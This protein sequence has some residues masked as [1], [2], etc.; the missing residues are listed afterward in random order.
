MA[1]PVLLAVD[2]D[3]EVLRAV[4]RDLRRG[5]GREYRVMRAD[6]AGSALDTL[7]ALKGRNDPVALMLVDQRMPQVS[8]VEFLEQA[9][10][11]YPD[12]KRVLLTAYADTDAA[13]R[14]INSVDLDYYL[15]KPWDPPEERLYPVLSDLLGDWQAAYRPP[16]EGVR[17]VGHQWAPRSHAVKDFLSRNQVPYQW[18]DFDGSDE[19]RNLIEQL[20][21]DP[22]KLPL[23]LLTDGTRLQEPSVSQLAEAVGMRTRA[24]QPFYDLIIVGGGPAGL[25]AAVYGGSEGLR[26]L[27]IEREAPG[28]QAGTSSMIRNY[29]GFPSGVTGADLARRALDQARLFEVEI[30][31]V[32]EVC[33]VRAE[34]PYRIIELAGGGEVSCHALLIATGVSW[35]KL[36]A[37]GIDKLTGAGVYYGAAT[38]EALGCR[39]EDVYVVGGANSAGQA[40][41]YFSRFARD[42]HILCRGES[43]TKGMSRY[44]IDEIERTP[45]IHV[46]TR[47]NIAEA[48]GDG[49]LESVVVEDSRTGERRE[50]P[51]SGL[52][53][54]IG[55]E[56]YT[57]WLDGVVMRDEK[58]F[59]LT[60]PDLLRDGKRPR[61]WKLDRDP[62]LLETSTP[63]VFAAGDV[64]RG[65]V[66]R[67]A[68]AVGDG[69]IS[70][71]A[72]H[73]YLAEV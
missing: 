45:N 37:P 39:D 20:D 57:D 26:T 50:F 11:L 12:A 46:H 23:V 60:G 18:L 1:R 31:S 15:M 49:R 8:G 16:F 51:A 43:L 28:G 35:R 33:G 21:A 55:A 53:I 54:M 66:K 6:S 25:A 30:L 3:T 5:Y 38:T 68:S 71:Q 34:G 72:I 48:R 2:D 13:I 65:S 32:Q 61:G 62:F 36:H 56:P 47:T 58:G 27:L 10:T 73:Q 4:D 7:K 69:S 64:R 14:A 70:V 17:V 63:G 19:A 52:F 24:E 44:L 22:M 42:V 67:V 9:R 40:A 41:M 29:L 59:V